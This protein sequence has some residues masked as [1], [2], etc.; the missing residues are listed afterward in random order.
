MC[1]HKATA[2]SSLWEAAFYHQGTTVQLERQRWPRQLLLL[3]LLPRSPPHLLSLASFSSS[4]CYFFPWCLLSHYAHRCLHRVRE[5]IKANYSV[6]YLLVTV[7]NRWED[8]EAAPN[9]FLK[10]KSRH[11]LSMT[12]SLAA[13]LTPSIEH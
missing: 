6:C 3:P 10:S 4:T 8:E 12:S 1:T 2:D 13:L 5:E 11:D 7:G 9:G